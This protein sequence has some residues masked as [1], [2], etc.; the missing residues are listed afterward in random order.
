MASLNHKSSAVG[1]LF[2]SS[3][4]SRVS[5]KFDHRERREDRRDTRSPKK[6]G[7][8]GGG[9]CTCPAA[10]MQRCRWDGVARVASMFRPKPR[11]GMLRNDDYALCHL[12]G[13]AGF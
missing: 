10:R 11:V 8:V 4:P 7:G 2:M 3:Q 6:R 13:L 1:I 9:T 12:V 5:L